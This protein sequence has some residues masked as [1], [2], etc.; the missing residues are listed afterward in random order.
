[1]ERKNRTRE[2]AWERVN[3][4]RFGCLVGATREFV[5]ALM[6]FMTIWK[7]EMYCAIAAWPADK[8]EDQ[9]PS[10]IPMSN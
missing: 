2:D 7:E 8:G 5:E 6:E 10:A 9:E 3:D 1:M 4:A